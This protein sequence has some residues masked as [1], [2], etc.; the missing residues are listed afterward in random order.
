MNKQLFISPEESLKQAL[1]KLDKNGE[2]ILFVVDQQQKLLGVMSDGDLRKILL[3][4]ISLSEKVETYYNREPVVALADDLNIEEKRSLF[5]S[6]KIGSMPV[7]DAN[8]TVVDILSWDK[9]FSGDEIKIH[10]EANNSLKN[11]PVVIMA[12]GKGTRMAP[13]TNVLPKPLI[14]LGEK[15]ILELIIDRFYEFGIRDYYFTLNYKGEMIRAY[16]D[17]IK[18]DYNLSYLWEKDFNGTASSLKL[19]PEKVADTLIVSNCDILVNANYEEVVEFHKENNA[20]LTIISSIQHHTIPYGVVEFQQG[21]N[22][23]EIVEKPEYT[24]PINT[25]IYVIDKD[26]LKHVKGNVL[27]HMTHLVDELINCGERVFTYPVNETDYIDIGQWE[28]YQNAV[29]NFKNHLSF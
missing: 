20:K 13:F 10:R 1:K 4:G 12:G 24:H 27:F 3:K 22:V 28:E 17:G 23:I 19:L 25:G 18:R 14:P 8:N 6:L 15:T 16:F 7:V 5:K 2:K 21:G 9:A 11:I 29:A 26:V